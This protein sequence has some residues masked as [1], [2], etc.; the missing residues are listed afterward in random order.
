MKRSLVL[1]AALMIGCIAGVA[2]KDIVVPARAQ[3][4]TGATYEYQIVKSTW[5]ADAEWYQGAIGKFA[6]EGW[7]YVD[8]I[9]RGDSQII[10]FE[11]PRQ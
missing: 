7:R 9:P 2:V 5:A 11:R 4:V 10:V 1:V 3:G 8:S 6:N